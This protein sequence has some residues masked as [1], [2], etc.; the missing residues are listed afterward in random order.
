MKTLL[1][2]TSGMALALIITVTAC[3]KEKTATSAE[4]PKEK[5]SLTVLVDKMYATSNGSEDAAITAAYTSLNAEELTQLNVLRLQKDSQL[6]AKKAAVANNGRV[7]AAQEITISSQLRKSKENRAQLEAEALGKFNKQINKLSTAEINELLASH[8]SSGDVTAAACP[9]E[10]FPSS[11]TQREQRGR[12]YYGIYLIGNSPGDCDFEYRF[13]GYWY[14]MYPTNWL[15]RQL[16]NSFGNVV[17]RRIIYY[18]DGYDT[19][20]LLGSTRVFLIVGH[21]GA[22]RVWMFVRQHVLPSL[23]TQKKAIFVLC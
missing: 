13:D 20:L 1:K 2:L 19:G 18:T 22:M 15:T 23:I 16:L 6:I 8:K 11:A 5:I 3:Q 17:S 14:Y 7:S 12:G 10:S 21:E 4:A 9:V